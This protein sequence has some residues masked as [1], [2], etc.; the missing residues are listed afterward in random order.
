MALNAYNEYVGLPTFEQK[1][2]TAL[3]AGANGISGQ[4]MVRVLTR[5]PDRWSK[6]YAL[7]RRP[8]QT[9]IKGTEP[10]A[11]DFLSGTENIKK[12]LREHN[13]TKVDYIFFFAY[14]ES[15]GPNGELWGGQEQMVKDNGKMLE[16]FLNATEGLAVK[17][18]ILQT[19]AKVSF[20]NALLCVYNA[21]LFGCV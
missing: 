1:G 3:V 16:D 15:S 19:G 6:V 9:D 4:H 17:R 21:A 18:V 13:I 14:K 11:L 2:L 10:V 5:D 12:T 8:P 7:S 20:R